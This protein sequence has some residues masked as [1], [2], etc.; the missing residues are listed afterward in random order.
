MF[1]LFFKRNTMWNN[2]KP[3]E[4]KYEQKIMFPQ[5]SLFQKPRKVNPKITNE[6]M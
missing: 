5:F 3:K 4:D 6:T 1:H 2:V